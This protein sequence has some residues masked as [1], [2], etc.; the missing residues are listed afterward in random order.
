VSITIADNVRTGNPRRGL[1]RRAKASGGSAMR[2]RSVLVALVVAL[3]VGAVGV[4]HSVGTEAQQATPAT[5]GHPL[6]GTWIV[7]PEGEDPTNPPSFDA[8]MADG[9]L[10]N[11]GSDGASVGSWEATGPRTAT[12]TFA[13]LV[14]DSGGTASFILRGYL[15]VDETGENL[16][17]GHSFT[18]VAAD[19]TVLAS[20]EGAGALGTRLNAEPLEEG[21]KT[22]PGYLTWTPAAPA[23]GTSTS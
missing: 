9:T 3:L 20:A 5:A 19:G 23:E 16:T 2:H 1:I 17:G 7:D 22:L 21:G 6:V 14:Q 18:L 11:I 13:G 12:F 8:F 15:E 4:V 10:V